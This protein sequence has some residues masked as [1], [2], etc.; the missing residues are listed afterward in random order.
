MYKI[1]NLATGEYVFSGENDSEIAFWTEAEAQEQIIDN[2]Y[3]YFVRKRHM[4]YSN[5]TNEEDNTLDNIYAVFS[6]QTVEQR[7]D[8]VIPKHQF[9]VV[10]EVGVWNV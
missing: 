2:R 7:P 8:N 5:Y 1:I 3:V 4:Y 10:E 9:E 6:P